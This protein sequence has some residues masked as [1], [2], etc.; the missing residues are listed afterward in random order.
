MY[1]KKSHLGK[2]TTKEFLQHYW[3]KKPLLI[4][5][6]FSNFNSII[7]K[8]ELFILATK[9]SAESR[10]VRLQRGKWTLAHGP[11]DKHLLTKLKGHWALLVQDINH[12]LPAAD[13][14][15]N[16]FNFIPYARLDDL[17]ISIASDGSGVGPHV[18]SYDVF[19]LQ[20]S[21][22]RLWQIAKQKDFS[23]Q[24]NVPLKILQTFKP[25]IEWVLEPGDMLYLPPNYAHNGIAMG[26]C[27]TYSIGFRAP[28]YQNLAEEF[29]IYLQDRICI[30]GIY[31]DPMLKLSSHPARISPQMVEK[32]SK[33]LNKI[34]YG[35][36][37]FKLF[38]GQYLT[39]PKLKTFFSSPAAPCSKQKFMKLAK[40]HGIS[41]DLKTKMLFID[42]M[43]FING[44]EYSFTGKDKVI[45]QACADE[46][47]SRIKNDI[48]IVAQ[49]VLYEW[50]LHGYIHC[51]GQV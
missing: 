45:M 32:V 31:E 2:I 29:L 25:E 38:L 26:E 12:F 41:L 21:G 1:M 46:R 4:R 24:P 42:K 8:K 13:H 44:E 16:L 28:T 49:D 20:G 47:K 23:L 37:E 10:L 40:Q 5:Q 33:I 34:Q 3:Q 7:S 48:S 36:K 19:L 11:F 6:A 43:F 50:Y 39:E 35:K 22:Q 30:P 27:M 51:Q 15:L 18:D 14:L 9:E 17:M